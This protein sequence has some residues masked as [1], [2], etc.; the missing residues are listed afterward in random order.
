MQKNFTR[1]LHHYLFTFSKTTCLMVFEFC[2]LA[3]FIFVNKSRFDIESKSRLIDLDDKSDSGRS[4]NQK[5]LYQPKKHCKKSKNCF[6]LLFKCTNY[7]RLKI[8]QTKIF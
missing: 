7:S 8:I 2:S 6:N 3:L 4:K 5:L 1:F